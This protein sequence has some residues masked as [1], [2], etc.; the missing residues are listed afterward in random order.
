MWLPYVWGG[1]GVLPQK[2]LK[3]LT[4]KPGILRLLGSPRVGGGVGG[5]GRY[6]IFSSDLHWSQEWSR[7]APISLKAWKAWKRLTADTVAFSQG[8]T[9]RGYSAYNSTCEWELFFYLDHYTEEAS[10]FLNLPHCCC[11]KPY[12]WNDR[13]AEG[14]SILSLPHF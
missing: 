11:Q 6:K 3:K 13:W 9:S 2:I 10:F 7:W 1:L 12:R 5:G 4:L 8:H 14:N